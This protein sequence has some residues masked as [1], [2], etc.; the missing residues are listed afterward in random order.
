[1]GD[2][3]L[4]ETRPAGN[5]RHSRRTNEGKHGLSGLCCVEVRVRAVAFAS[6]SLGHLPTGPLED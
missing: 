2:A 6:H 4:A 1:M 3:V 5:L